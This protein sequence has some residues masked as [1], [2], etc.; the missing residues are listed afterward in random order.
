M[1]TTSTFASS[2]SRLLGRRERGALRPSLICVVVTASGGA[3]GPNDNQDDIWEFLGGSCSRA[4]G[5][6][7]TRAA[8]SGA[9]RGGRV[10]AAYRQA[11]LAASG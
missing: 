7:G 4:D 10:A 1:P 6:P 8:W 2:D 11:G 5:V 3:A 9:A